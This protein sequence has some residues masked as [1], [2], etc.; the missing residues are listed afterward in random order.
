MKKLQK[1]LIVMGILLLSLSSTV[2]AM[3]SAGNYFTESYPQGN[4]VEVSQDVERDVYSFSY[5]TL[6]QN[7]TI[8]RSFIGAAYRLDFSGVTIGDSLRAAAE[9][10]AMT[11][12]TVDNNI[13]VAGRNIEINGASSS[14][15]IYAAGQYLTIGG[16]SNTAM[17]AGDTVAIN[18]VFSGDVY[19]S[20]TTVYVNEGA[21]IGGT[22]NIDSENDPIIADGAKVNTLNFNQIVEEDDTPVKTPAQKLLDK[23]IDI[24]YWTAITV[25]LGLLI[26]LLAHHSVNISALLT[27]RHLLAVILSGIG[28]L[29]L[30]PV[31]AFVLI[32]PFLTIPLTLMLLTVYTLIIT[33]SVPYAAAV[34]GAWLLPNM[35]KWL[36]TLIFCL[37]LGILSRV[38]YL[39]FV[40][41]LICCVFTFGCIA[42]TLYYNIKESFKTERTHEY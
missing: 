31:L 18:G 12:T 7:M 37:G 14:N 25:I 32:L 3:E 15:A 36:S 4:T 27:K 38:P 10:I 30:L 40:I 34:A 23:L 5:S 28:M 33:V 11:D 19:V 21:E 16:T 35:N 8:G 29:L 9:T 1:I 39:G 2:F 26:V 42:V 41:D 24:L 13:T 22:L 6:V 17:L 20:G